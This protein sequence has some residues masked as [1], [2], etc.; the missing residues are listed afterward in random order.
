MTRHRGFAAALM[1]ASAL[2]GATVGLLGTSLVIRATVVSLAMGACALGWSVLSGRHPRSFALLV[3]VAFGVMGLFSWHLV[4]TPSP[5]PLRSLYVAALLAYG[6]VLL[7][8]ALRILRVSEARALLLA[9]SIAVPLFIA[10]AL[11]APPRLSKETQWEINRYTDP[12]IWFRYRPNSTGR[13]YYPDN[14][15]GYFSSN[16]SPRDNWALQIHE[17][18]DA[19]LEHS[20]SQPGLMRV[21]LGK[22]IK[23]ESWHVKLRQAPFE[24][25]RR[26]RY[27]VRFRARADAPRRIA[28][29]VEQNHE[30]WSLISLYHLL[31]IQPDW[32]SFECPFV[33]TAS[34][35]NASI[36]FGLGSS[37]VPIEFMDVV[38][39]D[40]STGRDVEPKRQFFVSYR[41]NALGFRGPDYAIPAPEGTFRILALG[42]SVTFGVGVH[43]QHTFAAQL[44]S[45]L[46]AAAG[47]RGQ[48]IRYEVVNAGV[49]GYSTQDERVSYELF[50]SAYLPQVVLLV[51][52]FNDDLSYAEE[53][54][55][56]HVSISAEP[57]LSRLWARL[58]KLRQPERTYDYASCVRELLRLN[59]SCRQ[60]GARLAVVV[61]RQASSGP[62]QLLTD[63]V[64]EGVQGTDIPV[65]DLGPALLRDHSSEELLVH[66]I[67]RHPNEVA[68]RLAAEE[69]ERFLRSQGLLPS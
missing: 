50:S 47:A 59:E 4:Q 31:E 15:R 5:H 66:P 8:A 69:I 51:M 1:L 25:Q 29:T 45:R 12:Q 19:Q 17:D 44:E 46:N 55:L 22:G 56:G 33:A 16:D 6:A 60:R 26:K 10:D 63:V 52:V 61:F 42:D 37:D 49:S 34:E 41:F 3:I 54:R 40:L 64:N 36:S 2:A 57:P 18:S 7:A 35:S 67:D 39:H 62:W 24:I 68:H 32:R 9:F 28:C 30:P 13:N 23:T 21:T 65:L 11:M 58:N 20:A 43:E 27:A 48:P 14:P 53:V 38:L